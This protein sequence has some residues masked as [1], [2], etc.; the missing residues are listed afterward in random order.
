M[1]ALVHLAF[2]SPV[3][4]TGVGATAGGVTNFVLGRRWIFR[5][6]A[7]RASAQALRYALVSFVGMLLNMLGEYIAFS[8]FGIQYVVA[9]VLVSLAVSLLWN[10]P[11]HR[12]FVFRVPGEYERAAKDTKR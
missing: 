4:A 10:F 5:A 6:T 3:W 9:R 12:A 1:I 7:G 11:L 8:R 2:V